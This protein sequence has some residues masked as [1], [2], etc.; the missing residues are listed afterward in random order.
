[1]TV[2]IPE[3]LRTPTHYPTT[4]GEMGDKVW[5]L[6]N[7][8]YDALSFL[9]SVQEPF[10]PRI[11]QTKKEAVEEWREACRRAEEEALRVLERAKTELEIQ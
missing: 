5:L 6:A 11:K 3:Q 9:M 1:M 2:F 7:D 10:N 8:L 4:E